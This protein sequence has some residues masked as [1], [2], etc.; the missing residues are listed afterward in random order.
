MNRHAILFSII[1]D[2]KKLM[3]GNIESKSVRFVPWVQFVVQ[4]VVQFPSLIQNWTYESF[5]L[6]KKT[7]W[8][9]AVLFCYVWESGRRCRTRLWNEGSFLISQP[10]FNVPKFHQFS[11]F[12]W[13]MPLVFRET[14]NA[15]FISRDLCKDPSYI[16]KLDLD[17]LPRMGS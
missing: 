8:W 12:A 13:K 9:R 5:P 1:F 4:S 7:L 15:Y 10:C 6:H 17:P 2:V 11:N 3:L 14:W 16:F